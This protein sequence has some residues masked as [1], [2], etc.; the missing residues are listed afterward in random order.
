MQFLKTLFWVV[1][2]VLLAILA[3]RNWHDVTLHLWGDLL[4]DIKLPL[5]MA[6]MFFA[7]FLPPLLILRARLW[8]YRRRLESFDRQQA[9]AVA[10]EPVEAADDAPLE[11]RAWTRST[12]L[13]TRRTWTARKR[14]RVPWHRP[15]VV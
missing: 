8:T 13:L 9:A 5:L 7:G 12:L 2:V 14:S 10:P 3:S 4:M 11:P 15:P 1:I 6:L